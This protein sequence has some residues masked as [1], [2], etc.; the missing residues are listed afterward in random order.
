MGLPSP[1]QPACWP[2]SS[3]STSSCWCCCCSS[4]SWSLLSAWGLAPSPSSPRAAFLARRPSRLLLRARFSPSLL[5]PCPSAAACAALACLIGT[6]PTAAATLRNRG[7]DGLAAAAAEVGAG[8]GGGGRGS[9]PLRRR[10]LSLPIPGGGGPTLLLRGPLMGPPGPGPSMVGARRAPPLSGMPGRGRCPSISY[11]PRGG[12]GPSARPPLLGGGS[13]GAP[14][15]P[16]PGCGGG[17]GGPMSQGGGGGPRP[18]GPWGPEGGPCGPLPGPNPGGPNPGGLWRLQARQ[19]GRQAGTNS[20]TGVGVGVS[21]CMAYQQGAEMHSS[22]GMKKA[23]LTG[24][25]AAWA[26]DS[27]HRRIPAS[28]T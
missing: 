2:W 5:P 18:G 9:G 27:P 21:G 3:A 15:G 19:A 17:P 4:C 23:P 7:A 14:L 6:P 12:G 22:N 26:C 11:P 24:S 8:S 16:P 10:P 25:R 20:K 13:R 1:S 28:S